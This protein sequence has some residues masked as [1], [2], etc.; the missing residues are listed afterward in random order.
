MVQVLPKTNHPWVTA[1]APKS[2]TISG[3]PTVLDKLLRSAPLRGFKSTEIPV[4]VPAHTRGLFTPKD[5]E[6]I[7]ETTADA[8][9][10]G[11]SAKL[12]FFSSV[13]G[14]PAWAANFKALA[15]LALN[16]CLLE[17]IGWDKVEGEIPRLLK[18]RG[19]AT[20]T[21]T[22]V[23]SN[24]HKSLAAA[25]TAVGIKTDAATAADERFSHRPG[26][27][28][29]KLAIVS[30]SGRFP[31]AQHTDDFWD[32][33]YKG[34]DTCKEVPLRRWDV[35]THVDETG[36][37]RNKGGTRW[38]C[39][40]DFT[41]EFD[42]RFFS[43]SPKEAPQMD[44]A[45][46]MSLM[47]TYEAMERAGI[48]PDTTP[49]TQRNRIGVFHGVTSNDWMETNT[50][51][52][53]DTH[54][55]TGGNRG[56]IPGRINFCFEFSGPSYSNDTACSSSLAAIHLACNSLWR[57]DCD[58][59]VAGGTNM[60]FTPD[61]HT[62]LDKGFFLSRT[63]NCK[64]FDDA[65][66]G[67]CRAEGVGTVFIKRLED[68]L[69]DNDPILATILDAKT[70]H[71][72]MSDSMTRPH[73]GA[74]IENMTAVLNS[75]CVRPSELS[76]IEMHG[77][78]TQVG[79]AVEME[80]VLSVFAPNEQARPQDKPLFVGSA[81]ANVGHGEGVSGVT[82]LVKVLL[83]MQHNTIVPH[84]G[85]KP[86]SKI[87]HNYP[88]LGARNVHIAFEPKPWPRTDLPRRVLINN[89]SAAGGN[90]ALLVEDA[91]VRQYSDTLDPRTSHTV[92]V[93]GHVGKSLKTNL[94]RLLS[95]IDKNPT[96]SLSHLSYTTTARRWHHLHRVALTG[97]SIPEI[98][99]K[100]QT[101]ISTGAG[102]N[103]PKTK[104]NLIFAFT[105]QGSQY[106]GMGHQLFTTYPPFRST[107]HRL[108]QL[109]QSHGF[110]SFLHI[111]STP[112]TPSTTT[113]IDDLLPVTVQLALTALEMALSD[114]LKSFS[115]TPAAVI[116][117]SLGEYAA[118]YTA[119]VLSASDTL[120][121]VGRRAELLQERCQRGTHA[122]L[123]VRASV[124]E[125]EGMLPRGS[126]CEV[127]CVNGPH[128]TVLSGSVEEVGEAARVVAGRGVKATVLRLPFAF[129]SA[130][131]EGILG[132]FEGLVEGVRVM[133]PEVAVLSPLLGEVVEAEGVIGG[134][135]L[136]RH[137]REAVDVV[138]ALEVAREKGLVHDKTIV[139]EVGP[140][141]LLC[142]MVKMTLGT[143][144]T[145]LPT[146]G[147][148]AD[149]WPNLQ[150][151]L[152]TVYAGG[153]DVNWTAYHAPFESAKRVIPLPDYG[154][155]LKEYYI[156]YRGDWCL[157]RHEIKCNCADTGKEIATSAY[158]FPPEHSTVKKPSKLDPTKEAFP[159]LK[160]STT[161]HRIVEE[162]TEPLGATLTVE[163]DLSHP[164]VN[165][166]AQGHLVDNIPLATPS[167][168]ADIA[169]QLGS[170]SMARLRAGHPGAGAIDGLVSVSD[171]VVDKALIPHGDG[172][173]LL[174]TTLSMTWP[175]K[176]A[177]TTRKATVKFVSYL[178]SGAVDTEHATC[179]VR[180]TTDAHQKTVQNRVPA[181]KARI[182]RLREGMGRGEF[183]HFTRK[184]GYK[185]MSSMATFHPD[186]KL[187]DDMVLDEDGN[188][189]ICGMKFDDAKTEGDFAAH[190][191]YVDAITQVAGFAMNAKDE[192]DITKEVWV[193][194]GW[195][196]LQ[197]WGKLE[198]GRAYEVYVKMERKKE[199]EGE[200]A[201]GDVVVLE[202][203]KVV[204]FFEGLAVS[205]RLG[206]QGF[207][208]FA[209]LVK[210]SFGR[211]RARRCML[212]SSRRLTRAS[213]SVVA[214][215]EHRQRRPRWLRRLLPLQS[216]PLWLRRQRQRHP[217]PSPQRR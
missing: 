144:M 179:T 208:Y 171:L 134:S 70:N 92:T 164:S 8:P 181:Y 147:P 176:A 116:G 202:G 175:P 118:L 6:S 87:N 217:S 52:N 183:V 33:L 123:A 40:L 203:D 32:L 64:P 150:N 187:L 127:A 5:I 75:A 12:P 135:Y 27:A 19:I 48:V 189:A 205:A 18:F 129:H 42:P 140:K 59:A 23:I 142:G 44:P 100:L 2:T 91:P 7:L 93:S 61:G 69:A 210:C 177:A 45:Q 195:G 172:P 212:C 149:V 3:T 145:T 122:M 132:D 154:W 29:C 49:S 15:E 26:P 79:D 66:D 198:K 96:M 138:K 67:Y 60:I 165:S 35:K 31:E 22:P 128:D 41:A 58:T 188:E 85:I 168:Y 167:F 169:L 65:A 10:A 153:L 110:P 141:P 47:S 56:F 25:F 146:L 82:S 190:P 104:P 200:M 160:L 120:Y 136:A 101:A 108:D 38:G 180:F 11:Y 4:Y 103:R 13:T 125:L 86:G 34:I 28:R 36:K 201:R 81:K 105:G 155:D 74:Q 115:L 137:C 78:G 174:R 112:P 156:P 126:G 157:H 133:K 143:Q 99:T 119:G 113:T 57:G 24:A 90:T 114:L 54:F 196:G 209:D 97:S 211:S 109:S 68:A 63:G 166:I 192:T 194:H 16:Q 20:A 21:I 213:G 30:M 161:I 80:S 173:Q 130:Q 17:P 151:I 73:V 152:S 76:Y 191:A 46:R 121:L 50:A 107:L 207:V 170:Y 216:L 178:P 62:G 139:V 131:V 106:L 72:A 98:K 53:I 83:M 193:N 43:I 102:I 71:S 148:N 204:A 51:Q 89:F 199:A 158:Q 159:P 163:T 14:K 84:C 37:A 1:T 186:Y 184:R 215:R 197:I 117:H 9:W 39:W 94:E 162:K 214:S 182:A 77:T 88:D 124:K 111:Y 206:I 95:H 55:I 185:L